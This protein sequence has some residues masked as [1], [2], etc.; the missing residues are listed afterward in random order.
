MSSTEDIKAQAYRELSTNTTI[1]VYVMADGI[2]KR[3]PANRF[4]PINA[5]FNDMIPSLRG[6]ADS[7][8]ALGAT[9]KAWQRCMP[10]IPGWYPSQGLIVWG[11]GTITPDD[12]LG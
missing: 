5:A 6:L 7:M 12:Q 2:E 10:T 9:F 4:A 8:T 11:D 3:R 1:T